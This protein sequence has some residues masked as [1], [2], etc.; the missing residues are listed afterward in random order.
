[1]DCEAQTAKGVSIR[2]NDLA[3]NQHKK[4]GMAKISVSSWGSAIPGRPGSFL[5]G[6][7]LPHQKEGELSLDEG[8]AS[9]CGSSGAPIFFSHR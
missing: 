9:R 7:G 1:M 6:F 5:C 3:G 2:G 8:V 4:T